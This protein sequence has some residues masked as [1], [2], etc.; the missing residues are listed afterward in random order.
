M[1]EKILF[2]LILLRGIEQASENLIKTISGKVHLHQS[3]KY[4]INDTDTDASFLA[5][6]LFFRSRCIRRRH[7]P[8]QR[9]S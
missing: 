2:D 9:L 1:N 4:K 8:K 3:E 6:K 5:P 7:P